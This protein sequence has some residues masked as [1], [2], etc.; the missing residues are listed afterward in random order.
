M[1]YFKKVILVILSIILITYAEAQVYYI[2]SSEG[3]DQNDGLSIQ[4]PF[5]SI[6]KLNSMEF[7]PGDS[8]YFKSGDYWEGM[9]WLKG[10]GSPTNPIVVD[11]YGGNIK[12][13]INGYGYQSSILIFNDQHIE[14][15][16]LEL[17]NA[18]SH[19]DGGPSTIL[20]QTPG[21]FANGP[22][23]TWTN[24]FTACQLAD[25]NNG[26]MQ[27]FVM[28]VTDL[29]EGGANYRI[30][31]TVANQNWYFAPAQSLSIGLN[32]ITV[33]AVD[34]ERA[35]KFQFSTGA[36]EFDAISLNGISMY[37][38]S[39]KK[40]PGF[41]GAENSW[42]S[43]KNVRFG[44][45]VVASTQ[46]LENFSFNNLY[47][48]DIYPTPDVANNIHLGYGIK[49][50][51]QSDIISG[52]FNT[53]SDVKLVNTTITE[54]GHYGFWIKSL[55]LVGIDSVKNNEILVENC[56]FEHTGGSGFV[57]NKSENVLVQN[58]IFNHTGSSID[59]RMWKRGSGMWPFDCKNVVAQHNKFMN[60][61]GP[62]DSYGSHI[63]YGNE[64]V[65]F[66]YNY[67]FNNE[68]GFAEV[69]GDNINC[70]YR[71]N[72]SV[73]DGYRVDPDGIP[74]NKKGKIFWVS[75]YCGSNTI[76]CPSTGTF[77][78]NN[79]VF[80]NDSLNPEIYFWPN[81]GDVHVYNNLIVVSQ[82]GETIS[83]L[84]ENDLN[85]LYISHNL[86]YD[87]FRINLDSD[88]ENNALYVDPLLLNSDYMGENNPEA[89][90]IQN[91]SPA[92]GSGFLINGSNDSINYL[93]HNG[94][95]DYFGNIVSHNFPSNIGAFN[96]T[97]SNGPDH[98][99]LNFPVG[100]YIFSTY[101]LADNMAIDSILNPILSNIIIVKDYIGT[102]L[103]PEYNFNGIG[104]LT[105]GSGYQIKT[106]QLSSLTVSGTYL[107]PE[108]NSVALLAGWNM[109]G[110]LRMEAAPADLV[111]AELNDADN[112]V[113]AK[114]YFGSA[115]LPEF[116]FN[117]IG[118][119]EPGQG[120]QLKTNEAGVLHFLSN[121]SSY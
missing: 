99:V 53:I 80:V 115:F 87:A 102:A 9:F 11:V 59:N 88:L 22:N 110:Y 17:Y 56:V 16:G 32:T 1:V 14:I 35:V 6:E 39:A 65:V 19:L 79:T 5:Q 93:Q 52:L 109:I 46:D 10:S 36:V 60:A 104:D 26:A 21:L 29:P 84:I 100:W 112:L 66:Q 74:W 33:N 95:L 86:F 8:I 47:I 18:S 57:P 82:A 75:N 120:Y 78:Y 92:I 50:E 64:N 31:R 83:T 89:Y 97:F 7:S 73:N 12:P 30:V 3:Y 91:G 51:T 37:G 101:M 69:L 49:L 119:L 25:G 105:V 54:T 108:E 42:G 116:N 55:G 70:G 106:S 58:C 85:E 44:I 38:G 34:F 2:S 67:S 43:G 20:E 81:V 94:G 41:G 23:T 45:K 118:D 121:Q 90:Q 72:I 117:G 98:Q 40:L 107:N 28:N 63:D 96:G 114:N 103:L 27:T 61:H 71:Y 15:N 77:M 4:S 62:M 68:G 111:L 76:R 24:V 48:H 113:I 13:I